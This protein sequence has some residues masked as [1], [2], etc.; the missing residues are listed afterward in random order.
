MEDKIWEIM[1]SRKNLEKLYK[2]KDSKLEREMREKVEVSV[3]RQRK[4]II[5][6]ARHLRGHLDKVQYNLTYIMRPELIFSTDN[7]GSRQGKELASNY[8]ERHNANGAE[9][10]CR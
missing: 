6:L 8:G 1:E 10:V 5:D 2:E 4:E 7:A 3:R 9:V